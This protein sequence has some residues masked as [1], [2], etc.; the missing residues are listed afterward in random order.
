MYKKHLNKNNHLKKVFN[1]HNMLISYS[2][3][4]NIKSIVKAH[5]NNFFKKKKQNESYCNCVG[6]CK[7][8]LKEVSK[9]NYVKA[10]LISEFET[11]FYIGL[12]STQFRFSY[13]IKS[14]LDV[15][16]MKVALSFQSIFVKRKNIDHIIT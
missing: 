9:K 7:Y 4:A 5:N 3:T 10:T 1:K 6:S 16:Y 12:W 8:T 11:R 13:A 14:L 2:C 15:A